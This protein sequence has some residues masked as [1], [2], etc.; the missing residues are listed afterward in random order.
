MDC[1]ASTVP[2]CL[3]ST[4]KP[5]LPLWAVLP[6][7]TLSDCTVQLYLNPHNGPYSLYRPSVPVQYSYTS[8]PPMGPTACTDPQYLYSTAIPLFPYRPYSLFRASVPVQYSYTSTSTMG[9]TASTDPQC[10]YSTAITLLPLWTVRPVQS[11]CASTRVG[12]FNSKQ[13]STYTYTCCLCEV[14]FVLKDKK[15]A[16]TSNCSVAVRTRS[17]QLFHHRNNLV[18]SAGLALGCQ[19]TNPNPVVTSHPF[20]L[21]KTA[22]K[23]THFFYTEFLHT[24]VTIHSEAQNLRF[25]RPCV[26]RLDTVTLTD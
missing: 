20:S 5:L 18:P 10:L 9:R 11:L 1:M 6:V 17:K 8:T 26:C 15:V 25:Q 21:T 23:H 12:F 22:H 19:R 13:K 14:H 7:Q 24:A 2:Q 4:A 3:Y 16:N